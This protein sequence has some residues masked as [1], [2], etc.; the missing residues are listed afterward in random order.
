MRELYDDYEDLLGRDKPHSSQ[1]STT[2]FNEPVTVSVNIESKAKENSTELAKIVESKTLSS[3]L[4]STDSVPN[5]QMELVE[6]GDECQNGETFKECE[7][8]E[9]ASV[10]ADSVALNAESV[11]EAATI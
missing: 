9:A 3:Q 11:D 8:V 4:S 10:E 7:H 2:K 5:N 6:N 1:K